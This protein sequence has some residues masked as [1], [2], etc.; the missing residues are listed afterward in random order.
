VTLANGFTATGIPTVILFT[1]TSGQPGQTLTMT[2]G[3]QS[4]ATVV[5]TIVSG[6]RKVG[7]FTLSYMDV[8]V[9]GREF[10]SR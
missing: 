10:P 1:P 4:T 6:S 9:P 5:N 2:I 8:S 7:L 3:G